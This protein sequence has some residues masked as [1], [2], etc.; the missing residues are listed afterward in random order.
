MLRL[1]P[2]KINLGLYVTQKRADGFHNLQTL[3]FPIEWADI[4]EAL[5]ARA[6]RLHVSG[7]NPCAHSE[8]N[9]CVKAFRALQKDFG[10]A[11]A[12]IYLHKRVPCGA[13]LGGGSSNAAAVL[14]ALNEAFGLGLTAKGL[15]GYAAGLG[16]D[17]PFFLHSKPMMAQ[18]RGDLLSPFDISLRGCGLL[19]AKPDIRISTAQAYSHIVPQDSRPP[20]SAIVSQPIET[21]RAALTNDFEQWAFARHPILAQIKA[22]MYAGGAAYAAMSGSGSAVFG[23]FRG[24]KPAPFPEFAPYSVFWQD[25]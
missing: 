17:C 20:L 14:L 9:L 22:A 6:L 4:V 12:D 25:L 7:A 24:K 15:H 3:F 13:G 8:D 1:S 10:L 16:S 2:A 11:G 23:I 21:W 19:I 18:G 5:P